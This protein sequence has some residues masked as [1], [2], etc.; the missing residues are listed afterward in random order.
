VGLFQLPDGAQTA[1]SAMMRAFGF[2]KGMAALNIIAFW[3]IGTPL[4]WAI[5]FQ[6]KRGINGLWIGL[7]VG[8]FCTATVGLFYMYTFEWD[9]FTNDA[10]SRLRRISRQKESIPNI[11]VELTEKR[12]IDAVVDPRMKD[13]TGSEQAAQMTKMLQ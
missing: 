3:F 1:V 10:A 2:Q 12:N 5:A 9:S 13:D 7:S 4:G 6:F 8:L 11:Q